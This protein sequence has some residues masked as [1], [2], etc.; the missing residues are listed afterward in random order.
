MI[1]NRVSR[2]MGARRLSQ[3]ELVRR[4][5]L[6]A[7]TIADVY[8]ARVQRVDLATLDKLCAALDV[9]VGDVLEYRPDGDAG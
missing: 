1:V 9:S 4:T 2:E 5:G 3:R 6:S 8:H 7:S